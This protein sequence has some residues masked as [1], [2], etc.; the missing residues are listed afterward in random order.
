MNLQINMKKQIT[1]LLM[2]LVSFFAVNSFSGNEVLTTSYATDAFGKFT[3]IDMEFSSSSNGVSMSTSTNSDT[4]KA[5]NA[6]ITLIKWLSLGGAIAL[7][8]VFVLNIIKM[9]TAGTNVQNRASAQQG[10]VWSGA[11]AALLTISSTIFF[12]IQ[13]SLK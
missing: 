12:F 3:D 7:L 4:S 8:G 2:V 13:G 11:S 1:M 10:L 5:L 6:F 9:G